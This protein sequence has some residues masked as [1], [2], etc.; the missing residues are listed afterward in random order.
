M[1]E[2]HDYI[3]ENNLIK[4]E[5]YKR[6]G[7]SIK[8]PIC[9][10]IIIEPMQC[11]KCNNLFC[12][13]CLESWSRVDKRCPNRCK[14]PN[15]K[16]NSEKEALF[17]Q[18][19]FNCKKCKKII[20]YSEMKRHYYLKCGTEKSKIKLYDLEKAMPIKGIFEKIDDKE[21]MLYKPDF[22]FKS[23]SNIYN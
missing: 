16:K 17:S 9:I 13:K 11:E 20:K 19:N 5:A 3:N 23:K 4:D 10:D 21:D 2:L 14:N 22:F 6:L 7:C 12:K 8:C 18:L 1:E 15:Y